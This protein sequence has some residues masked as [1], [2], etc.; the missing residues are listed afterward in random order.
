M[1]A[2]TCDSMRCIN[3]ELRESQKKDFI[4]S[5]FQLEISMSRDTSGDLDEDSSVSRVSAWK[6]K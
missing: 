2:V 1:T 3:E 4:S 5:E 6:N